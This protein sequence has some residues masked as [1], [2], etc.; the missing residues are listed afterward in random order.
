M[1]II[2]HHQTLITGIKKTAIDKINHQNGV[3]IIFLGTSSHQKKDLAFI[4]LSREMLHHLIGLYYYTVKNETQRE[5]CKKTKK[6][7]GYTPTAKRPKQLQKI[8]LKKT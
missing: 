2:S 4:S 6:A 1:G 3:Q 5:T 7:A 8:L